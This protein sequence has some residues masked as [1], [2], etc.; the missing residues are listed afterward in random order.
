MFPRISK[1]KENGIFIVKMK[2]LKKSTA[3]E[4]DENKCQGCGICTKICPTQACG[5][6]PIGGAKKEFL[7]LEDI[8]PTI[9]DAEK[10]S[11]CGLC[12]FM[13]PWDAITLKI[14]DKEVPREELLLVTEH[15]VPEL[16]YIMHKC[17]EG[18][19]ES[20]SYFEGKIEFD[21][22]KCPGGCNTCV[23]VCPTAALKIE[24]PDT[25]WDKGRKMVVDDEACFHCG[26]CTN[27][28]PVFDA[29]KLTITEVKIK[30]ESEYKAILWDKVIEQLKISRMRG[31]VKIN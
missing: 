17:K 24:K 6:G 9:T 3:L 10:C 4:I 19:P 12:V 26:T 14:D 11:Y 22:T 25:P 30:P 29:I 21:M 15:A 27:A 8:I 31:N 23:D 13:C 1:V 28:C 16:E 7:E 2:Y 5:R 18:V 20:R